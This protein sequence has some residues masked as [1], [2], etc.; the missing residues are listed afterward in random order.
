[1][2]FDSHIHT[3]FSADSEMRAVDALREAEKQGLGLVFT[4]HLDYD[5][6]AAGEE[7]FIFDPAAYWAAYEPLRAE[8][9]LSL[10]VEMGMM[11][12][13]R[14][15]NAAFLRRVPFDFVLG[16]IHFLDGK[17]L[18]FPETF[19]SREKW[20][21][22]HEYFTV[23]RDEIYAHP[24]INALAHIDYI[25]R[26]AP[27]DNPEISYGDFADDIDAV[28]HA[29]IETETVIEINTRRL[30]VPRGLK[31]L[32]PVYRRYRELGGHYVTI[33]SDAH[34]PAGVGRNYDRARELAHAFDLQIVTFCERKMRLCKA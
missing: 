4:E 16:S 33:G 13:V 2:Y 26:N 3:A 22:Y 7:E 34:V 5:Y 15:K 30:S 8:G 24:F 14:E 11:A 21:M 18:Y 27:F 32:A 10:G 1:M 23:M 9:N 6:P 12:S 19:E 17:D 28:L 29:L 31:E 20:E 25:A